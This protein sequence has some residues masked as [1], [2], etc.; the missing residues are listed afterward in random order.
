M[1]SLQEFSPPGGEIGDRFRQVN[2]LSGSL[3]K[4][5]L[6][7]FGVPTHKGYEPNSTRIVGLNG[8]EKAFGPFA[9]EADIQREVPPPPETFQ[10]FH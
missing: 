1:T 2:D 3:G 7:G 9:K 8:K 4:L 6:D 10:R 5:Q